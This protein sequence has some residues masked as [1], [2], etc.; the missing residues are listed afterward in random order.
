MNAV[1]TTPDYG[2]FWVTAIDGRTSS[3]LLFGFEG[4]H[5]L[6]KR[7]SGHAIEARSTLE[8]VTQPS[9][10]KGLQEAWN[11]KRETG[12]GDDTSS[13]IRLRRGPRSQSSLWKEECARDAGRAKG[14]HEILGHNNAPLS[15]S[16]F[17]RVSCVS[18]RVRSYLGALLGLICEFTIVNMR[19][20]PEAKRAA[21]RAI[22][23]GLLTVPEV[24]QLAGV[25]RQLIHRW[26]GSR[27]LSTSRA[28]AAKNV[29]LWRKLLDE[30]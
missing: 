24:A 22:S 20:D 17:M 19:K 25:S 5:P 23:R 13:A 27:G 15:C 28:R 14:M 21:L 26:C 8:I 11:D 2:T 9:W 16:M 1:C 6:E 29:K 7:S 30:K 10:H 18:W 3:I 12:H 4:N